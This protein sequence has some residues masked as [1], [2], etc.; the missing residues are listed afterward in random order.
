M[1]HTPKSALFLLFAW[2]SL[3]SCAA[4]AQT[5]EGLV[6]GIA[7]GDTLTV[8]DAARNSHRIRLLGIDAPE[9]GQAFGERSKQSLAQ[10][11]FRKPVSVDWRERDA[12]GRIL[13]RVRVAHPDCR[14]ADC[15]K[16]LDANLA[17]LERGLAWWNRKFADGQF[18]GD[19]ERYARAEREARAAGA[20]LWSERNPVPPWRWRHANRGGQ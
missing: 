9:H 8:L 3:A 2:L 6:I 19:A 15:P 4:G 14:R 1:R 20:G 7:D 10:L 11:A 16:T 5:L 17:Q 13:G 18:P 12:Y